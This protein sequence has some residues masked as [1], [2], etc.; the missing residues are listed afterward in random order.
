MTPIVTSSSGRPSH[1][2]G[3]Q[4]RARAGDIP[5][6][7]QLPDAAYRVKIAAE[8][9][10]FDAIH[11]L[12]YQTFV[13]EIPQHPPH[14]SGRLV[15][16]FHSENTYLICV[17]GKALLGMVAVRGTRPFSLDI[18]IPDLDAYLPAGRRACELRLLA[19]DRPH[20]AGR[21]LHRLLGAAWRYCTEQQYEI[22]LISGTTRQL[23][24]YRHLGFVPFASPVGSSEARFQP[25]MASLAGTPGI[26]KLFRRAHVSHS[27]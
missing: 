12:N 1:V 27:A 18:K 14:P 26:R 7:D 25:M 15:D 19:V 23:A 17:S 24:L 20:R 4:S 6:G 10:E 21:L 16:R 13:E 11:R 5:H 2:R 22:A 8:R 3:S 9:W